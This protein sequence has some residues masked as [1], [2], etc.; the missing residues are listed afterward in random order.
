MRLNGRKGTPLTKNRKVLLLAWNLLE[1]YG[2]EK[3]DKVEYFDAEIFR[4]AA[5][6]SSFKAVY[7]WLFMIFEGINYFMA[8]KYFLDPGFKWV[9]LSHLITGTNIHYGPGNEAKE[10]QSW[11]KDILQNYPVFLLYLATKVL[12]MYANNII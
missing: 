3:F 2:R 8:V 11:Y 7:P 4:N 10:N 1:A 5:S 9:D 12:E 6:S